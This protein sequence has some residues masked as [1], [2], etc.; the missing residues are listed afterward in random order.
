MSETIEAI[1]DEHFTFHTEKFGSDWRAF[2][3]DEFRSALTR[4][5]EGRWESMETAPKDAVIL[6]SLP[7]IGNLREE[8]RRV[9]EGR[10]NERQETWTSVN[11]FILLS[12]AT[13]WRELPTPPTD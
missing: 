12:E 10:W 8:D 13:R 7:V 3:K 11:G 2:T 5:A 9:F 4:A 6:L 1:V